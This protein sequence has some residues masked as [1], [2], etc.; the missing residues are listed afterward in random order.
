MPGSVAPVSDE[1]E[2]LL[3]YLAQQRYVL[4]TL[5]LSFPVRRMWLFEAFTRCSR[6]AVAKG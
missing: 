3:A 6:A 1:R 2:G 5:P 4:H